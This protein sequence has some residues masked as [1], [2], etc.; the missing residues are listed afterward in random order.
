[1]W[2]WVDAGKRRRK[3]DIVITAGRDDEA[4]E[5]EAG[6][7]STL[8]DNRDGRLS[9]RNAMGA[10]FGQIGRGTPA[11][12]TMP[13]V[14]DPFT[15]T[16]A[17]GW[18]S[19]P[20][21]FAWT[22]SNGTAAVDGTQATIVLATNN[23]C[24]N[25]V[26][27]AGSPDVE[28]VWSTTLDVMP[29]GASFVSA[30]LLRHTDASN[31]VRAHVELQAAGTVAVKVQ[32]VYKGAQ[33]DRLA[34]TATSV[35]Y[36]AGTK[37][38]GKARA[39]G[40][41]IMVKT[42]TGAL[43][44]EP[45]TWQGVTTDSSVEGVGTGWFGWRINTNAGTYTAKVDDFTLVN[46]LW[47]GNV[48]E[49]APKWPEKSG[50]DSTMPLVGAGIIRRLST[51]TSPVN[52]PL[53]SHLS[54]QSP[55]TYYPC[56]EES[57][58]QHLLSTD[59]DI[60]ITSGVTFAAVDTL[61]GSAP[62]PTMD[63]PATGNIQFNIRSTPTPDGFAALWFFKMDSLPAVPTQMIYLRCTGT[64]RVFS[65]IVDATSLTWDAA[66]SSGAS[67]AGAG[68]AWAVDPTQWIAMQLETN[69]SGGTVSVA[70]LWHQIGEVD[71]WASTDTYAGTS[72]KPDYFSIIPVSDNM[73]VAHLW[74]GDN[75]L[76]FVDG[77]FTLVADGYAT[78]T[79][80]ARFARLCGENNVPS[81][82]L[83]GDS[84]PMGRQRPGKLVDLLRE[85][86][87]AD[88]GVLCERGN[89]LM[90]IPRT[91]RYN[92][93]VALALDWALGH[94]DE[95]PEPTDDDQ[96]FRNKW[97]LSRT[98]GAQ[99]VTV[100]DAA[101]IAKTGTL[102]DSA[103]LNI[104]SDG[105]L[106]DFA[107]WMLNQSTA[108][109]LRWPRV[110]INLIAHPEFAPGWLACR[111][112]SRITIANPP[113]A[114]LAGQTIDLIIE[115]FTETLNLDKW[116]VELACSPAELL[117][118][119]E[120]DSATSLWDAKSSYVISA[121]TSAGTSLK[122]GTKKIK[123]STTATP[124]LM[125]STGEVVTVTT[126]GARSSDTKL[127]SGAFENTSDITDWGLNA[128]CTL[129]RSGTFAHGGSFS[130]L[131]T[132]TGSPTQAYIRPSLANSPGVVPGAT[133]TLGVWVRSTALLT[134]V[135][136]TID[137]YDANGDYLSTDDSGLASLA[138]GSFVQRTVTATAPDDAAF[139]GYGP[140]VRASPTA[141]TVL[142]VD[143]VTI[144]T[145]A[146]IQDA[147]VARAINGVAKAIPAGTTVHAKSAGRWAL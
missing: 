30:A 17:S 15:R 100:E 119:G 101:S 3:A 19:T 78:E 53:L 29:T 14:D 83:D 54:A 9:P 94:L 31:L 63:T 4:N 125:L 62:V 126:M 74:F 132:V 92:M 82:V 40:P 24:R 89:A 20:E 46:L 48:P 11:R 129:A 91:R 123:W 143:D 98:G 42:W 34:L 124:D 80:S 140:S 147:T 137:W 1:L 102:D 2:Q 87:E 116:D 58:A 75:D 139:L 10:Y 112:G 109:F 90:Y 60:A 133:Y 61:A 32:R 68:A 118:V 37:V 104:A 141:G 106:I 7:L 51:G 108:D 95:A 84:E 136:A 64:M 113:S 127:I 130:G 110:K 56:E 96:R 22:V 144:T 71:Y 38:W 138:S 25:V 6:S 5:V 59:G 12:V 45:D 93:P 18:G 135:R 85:C 114:Q 28:I 73:A 128:N 88:Q 122:L 36:S 120:W 111:I 131:M 97:K 21:G 8:M 33:S 103:E 145:D 43:S 35:T 55:F 49:W 13:R 69:V 52:S 44:D 76:P 86:E 16:V 142:Y 121:A 65:L 77:T 117:Q 57:G 41:Y 81:Y 72:T 39:D 70:L 26:V 50:K 79:A 134:D 99:N 67:I 23:A 107:S 27:D 115:G 47:S 146:G 105:R 66:D